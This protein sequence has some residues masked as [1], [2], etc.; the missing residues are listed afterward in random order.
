MFNTI[1]LPGPVAGWAAT[2]TDD[3]DKFVDRFDHVRLPGMNL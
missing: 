2:G 1:A 3:G